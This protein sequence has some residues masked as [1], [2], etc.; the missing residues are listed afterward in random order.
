MCGLWEN[1]DLY[2]LRIRCSDPLMPIRRDSP[3]T[4]VLAKSDFARIAVKPSSAGG[5]NMR[6][7]F[8]V[9]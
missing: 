7:R 9:P 2:Q 5:V 4:C 3:S 1:A 6:C 8:V